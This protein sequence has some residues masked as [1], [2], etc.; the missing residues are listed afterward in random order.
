MLQ[1]IGLRFKSFFIFGSFIVD[2]D[3]GLLLSIGMT[4]LSDLIF[5]EFKVNRINH[6]ARYFRDNS[7]S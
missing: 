1:V 4:L 5:F 3:T 2:L 7:G 6:M